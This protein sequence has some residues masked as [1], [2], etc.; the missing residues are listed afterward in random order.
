[1]KFSTPGLQGLPGVASDQANETTLDCTT[2]PFVGE[3]CTGTDGDV[4]THGAAVGACGGGR[5]VNCHGVAATEKIEL[6]VKTV[7]IHVPGDRSKLLRSCAPPP[8]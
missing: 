3:T 7:Q 8:A 6:R 1:M 5:M 4:G 2:E